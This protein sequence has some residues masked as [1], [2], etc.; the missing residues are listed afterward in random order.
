MLRAAL[1]V[2]ALAGC[3]VIFRVD[4]VSGTGDAPATD[5]VTADAVSVCA[6]VLLDDEFDDGTVCAPWG[7][8]RMDVGATVTETSGALVVQPAANM[9][10]SR[11]GC[12]SAGAFPF[13]TGGV[14]VEVSEAM[15]GNDGE[16]TLLVS[17][18]L[19]VAIS[20][21][22]NALVFQNDIGT[23]Q[24]G[25]PVLYL[26]SGMRFWRIRRVDDLTISGEFSSDGVSWTVLG[27][28]GNATAVPTTASFGVLAGLN[29][30]RP[31]Q[32]APDRAVYERFIV[33]P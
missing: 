13:G 12:V 17:G 20:V 14:V 18:S 16:F 23:Q 11:G 15:M 9:I 26:P 5:T 6:Q 30:N 25:S 7:D 22:N 29:F 1:W 32:P 33:C 8:V 31:A 28:L 3:D 2:W 4:H 10:G 27:M 21:A 24:Y 19:H